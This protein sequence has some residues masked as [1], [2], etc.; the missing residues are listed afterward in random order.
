[1]GGLQGLGFVGTIK[2]IYNDIEGIC[3]GLGGL[4]L[5]NKAQWVQGWGAGGGGRAELSLALSTLSGA[6]SIPSEGGD[7]RRDTII[8]IIATICISFVTILLL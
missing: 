6:V 4:G 3:T 5:R 7:A 8:V 2:G 1:M